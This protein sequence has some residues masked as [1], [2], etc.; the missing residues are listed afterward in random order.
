MYAAKITDRK[1][2]RTFIWFG[3]WKK[4][5]GAEISPKYNNKK[6]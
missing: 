4:E 3:L 5:D 6:A 2:C 1:A